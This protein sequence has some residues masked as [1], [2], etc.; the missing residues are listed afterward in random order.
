[1]AAEGAKAA[2]P[3]ET[4]VGSPTQPHAPG[5]AGQGRA[6]QVGSLDLSFSSF[7]KNWFKYLII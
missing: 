4:A 2:V 7:L 6:G 3:G 1:M 5:R